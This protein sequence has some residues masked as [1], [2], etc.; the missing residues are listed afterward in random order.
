MVFAA[1][2]EVQ[3]YD[4]KFFTLEKQEM[5]EFHLKVGENAL[6]QIFDETDDDSL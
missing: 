5:E 1:I 4:H 2:E 3:K 6:L